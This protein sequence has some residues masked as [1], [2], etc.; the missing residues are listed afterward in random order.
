[1]DI[2][3]QRLFL[4]AY[5]LILTF[6]IFIGIFSRVGAVSLAEESTLLYIKEIEGL[7]ESISR[8]PFKL[9]V[10]VQS[11]AKSA[12]LQA[13]RKILSATHSVSFNSILQLGK[14]QNRK[15]GLKAKIRRSCSLYQEQ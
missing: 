1:M 5:G 14:P 9:L 7:E 12:S 6:S 8:G 11:L 3:N 10:Q 13:R 4:P 15:R 2:H